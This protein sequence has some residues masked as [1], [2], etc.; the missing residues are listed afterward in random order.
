MR[1]LFCLPRNKA[2][3]TRKRWAFQDIPTLRAI[4]F[5]AADEPRVELSARGA[6]GAWVSTFITGLAADVPLDSLNLALP[7]AELYAGA[8]LGGARRMS[9]APSARAAV[10]DPIDVLRTVWGY[11]AFRGLQEEIIG[12]VLAG[13]DAPGADAHRRRQVPVLPVAGAGAWTGSTI[14]VSPLIA[15]MQDQVDA[16]AQLGVRAAVLN[17]TLDSATATGVER[18]MREGAARPGLRRA[19]AADG[20]GLPRLLG[21]LPI[22]PCSRSTRRTASRSGA[23][24]SGPTISSCACCTSASPTCRASRSPPPPTRRPGAR[25]S[26]GWISARAARSSP[27]STGPTS[28]TAS[29]RS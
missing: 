15:L 7:M 6:D 19:G 9:G 28:A 22:S 14:V 11:P 10:R 20:A 4:L 29:C 2:D 26:S 5:V 16:L 17:S 27:V 12:H 8:D 21:P 3:L 1:S 24:I 23:T 25:S 13:G 18:A